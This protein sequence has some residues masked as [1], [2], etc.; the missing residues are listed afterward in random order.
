MNLI[1]IIW[2]IIFAISI[3]YL[4]KKVGELKGYKDGYESGQEFGEL[5]GKVKEKNDIID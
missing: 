1:N 3:F 4:G 2:I 5:L